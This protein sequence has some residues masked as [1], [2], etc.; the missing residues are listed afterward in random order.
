M[1][2][3]SP[4]HLQEIIFGSSNS[5]ISKKLSQLEEAGEIR[6]LAPRVYT[7]NLE[8]D[9]KKIVSRNLFSILGHLYPGAV[10]S[11]RSGLELKPTSTGQLFLTY[12]YTKKA[13]LPGITIRF[14]EGSGPIDG[15]NLIA[16]GL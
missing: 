8:D 5:T 11:H 1:E 9:P 12:T 6:K 15:D 3:I 2:K 16:A 10:L 14:L 4:I 13:K 7:G